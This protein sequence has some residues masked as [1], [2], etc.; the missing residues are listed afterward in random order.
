MEAG[1]EVGYLLKKAKRV[2]IVAHIRPDGDAVS[3][4]LGLGVALQNSHKEVQMVMKDG[5]MKAFKHLPGNDQIVK[6][7][8]GE[9]DCRVVVDCSDLPRV[10]GAL[11]EMQPDINIDHH[12]TNLNFAKVKLST[13]G[14][15]GNISGTCGM[16]AKMG[17]TH[18]ST[19]CGRSIKRDHL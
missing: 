3:S 19:H 5:V 8:D 13:A 17:F 11:G 14:I 6:K 10:G 1:F 12:V 16:V 4:L 2:L 18:Y 9:F 15:C 7:P